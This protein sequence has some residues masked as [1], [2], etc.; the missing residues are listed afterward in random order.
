MRND[1]KWL[2][3]IKDQVESY[4]EPAPSFAWDK[5]ST[6]LANSENHA[7]KKIIPF[8]K[9][10]SVWIAAATLLIGVSTF[11]F[12]EEQEKT[13]IQKVYVAKDNYASDVL[14]TIKSDNEIKLSN[15]TTNT[16]E[17]EKLSN[18][19]AQKTQQPKL[20]AIRTET[21]AKPKVKRTV[22]YAANKVVI[23]DSD[24]TQQIDTSETYTD[25]SEL[26]VAT[27]SETP[28]N[29]RVYDDLYAHL[30]QEQPTSDKNK[31]SGFGLYVGGSGGLFNQE[32]GT[33]QQMTFR[34][35]ALDYINSPD[36]MLLQKS[37]QIMLREGV[38]Y[39]VENVTNK[40]FKHRQP[41]SFGLNYSYALSN[42]LALES[43]LVYTFIS[44]DVTD[45]QSGQFYKQ[46]FN[47]LGVPI[48]VNWAFFN[49]DKL[50]LYAAAGGMVEI[51]VSG[52]VN[53]KTER[54]TRPQFSTQA[55]IG[56]MYKV[57]NHVGLYVEPG[58]SYFFNDGS[59]YE[60]IR[61]EK[62]FNFNFNTGVRLTF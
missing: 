52:K 17:A 62:P 32:S 27:E 55:G 43:G 7:S 20:V 8:Y 19:S 36:A 28:A 12:L 26:S 39:F 58:A 3:Q 2:K 15:A 37:Q 45:V 60:T 48:K 47:Y 49:R 1:D 18:R 25:T 46:K 51:A 53:G 35:V 61:S 56:L 9:R 38:P 40:K 42:T 13:Q 22:P 50:S 29:T 11:L 30:K 33:E 54:P 10:A 41:I 59:K 34:E 24:N 4:E 16:I 6:S 5:I 44:S 21:E 31:A 23:H 57:A 14:N